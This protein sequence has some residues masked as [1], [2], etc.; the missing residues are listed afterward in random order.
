MMVQILRIC[1]IKTDFRFIHNAAN[2]NNMGGN[3]DPHTLQPLLAKT[4][5]NAK[6]S[7]QTA[8]KVA[9]AG[10]ILKSTVFGLGCVICVTGSGA[11]AQVRIVAGAGV[12]VADNGTERRAAGFAVHKAG[13]DFRRVRLAAGG[14]PGVFARRTAA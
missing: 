12:G 13:E 5:G 10:S 4:T 8:G 14:G 1:P 7:C 9:A 6:G 11:I 2:G 3:S